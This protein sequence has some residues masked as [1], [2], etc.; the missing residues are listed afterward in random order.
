MRIGDTAC[1]CGVRGEILDLKDVGDY[2]APSASSSFS[3]SLPL[4]GEEG[5]DGK[6]EAKR[7]ERRAQTEEIARLDLLVPNLE[8]AT[9]C[10]P[11]Y[12]PGNNPPSGLAQAL[13]QRLL[14]LLHTCGFVRGGDLRI[15]SRSRSREPRASDGTGGAASSSSSEPSSSSSSSS[16]SEEEDDDNDNDD[17]DITRNEEA[18]EEQL[19]PQIKAYWTLYID[20]LFISLDGNPFDAAWMCMLAALR[21]TTL[22]K[23][24]WDADA[25]TVLCSDRVDESKRLGT[26]GLPVACTFG[27]FEGEDQRGDEGGAVGNVTGR[28]KHWILADPDA[29]EE[30]LCREMTTV[31]VDADGIGTEEEEE[32]KVLRIE[33]SGGEAVGIKEMKELVGKAKVRWEEWKVV[34]DERGK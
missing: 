28:K 4:S 24:W 7:E 5:E 1:V 10:S 29:F 22:P 6:R 20:I 33:K 27:A 18:D 16:S 26:I 9:G 14:T 25:E 30:G 3:S 17:E 11:L 15:W 12:L 23:A 31:V 19:K 2:R 8:L 32:L 13:S 21:D 34:L